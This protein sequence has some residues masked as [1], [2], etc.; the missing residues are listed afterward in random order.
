MNQR[1]ALLLLVAIVL[2]L[3][4][5][6]GVVA[7]VLFKPSSAEPERGARVVDPQPGAPA[8]EPA[9]AD[10][11]EAAPT[12]G[13]GLD[14][15]SLI[16]HGVA[17]PPPKAP[18]TIRLA[19]Y[20][21][22]NLFDDIDDP[23]LS[24]RYEDI[25]DTKPEAHVRAVAEAIR[26]LDADILALQEVESESVVRA[27]R[28]EHL[29][30]MGYDHLVSIDAGDPRGIEQALL[31][32][33]PVSDVENWPR[34]P[35]AGMHPEKWGNAENWHAGEPITFHRSPL[36]VT[37]EIPG[38]GGGLTLYIV[39][40]KSGRPG[41]YWRIAEAE[42]LVTLLRE[43]GGTPGE[44]IAILGDF[45]A[46]VRDPSVQVYAG[47]GFT[48]GLADVADGSDRFVTHHSGR[49]IDHILVNAELG[50]ALVPGSG[51]VLGTPGLPEGFDWR[52]PWRPDG[53]ASD[54]YPVAVDVRLDE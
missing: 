22:E 32:R 33:F 9:P 16:R 31:S 27:L 17:E 15:A 41:E 53:Y 38:S 54:H 3:T 35:L 47:A 52:D 50:G 42:G 10:T 1:K 34:R 7:G 30:G 40:A 5:L 36:R 23:A 44:R 28:D 39:H 2:V 4:A 37:V 18:G 49:R 20:N 24:G 51:F 48:D 11:D 29:A 45:N 25:D 12:E 21:V 46:F 14:P 13:A 26:R 6:G 19:T 43:A 8:A